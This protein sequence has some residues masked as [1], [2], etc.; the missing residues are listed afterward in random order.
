MI[1]IIK[2]LF[3]DGIEKWIR[4]PIQSKLYFY[5]QEFAIYIYFWDL[6]FGKLR[7]DDRGFGLWI[8]DNLKEINI[9]DYKIWI[10]NP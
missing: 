10:W 4:Y 1:I 9:L 2:R 5:I 3:Y 8:P 7:R 6:E